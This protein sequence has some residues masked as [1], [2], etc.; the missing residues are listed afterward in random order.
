[1]P[2]A[3]ALRMD[4]RRRFRVVSELTSRSPCT[5]LPSPKQVGQVDAQSR[6]IP[7]MARQRKA[8][9][10]ADIPS[11]RRQPRCKDRELHFEPRC[12]LRST[13]LYWLSAVSAQRLKMAV[14]STSA[15]K[16]GRGKPKA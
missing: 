7:R 14:E 11:S 2:P 10:R 15:L 13:F 12:I 16:A 6:E 8:L 4:L 5:S 1:M 9:S 3:K